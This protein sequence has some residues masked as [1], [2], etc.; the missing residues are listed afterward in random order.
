[1]L[2]TFAPAGLRRWKTAQMQSL[3]THEKG[4]L[5]LFTPNVGKLCT[6]SWELLH[7]MLVFYTPNVGKIYTILSV[8]YWNTI[9]K[10]VLYIHTMISLY[11]KKRSILFFNNNNQS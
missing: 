6:K 8:T 9:N 2:G 5:G 10:S 11:K 3:K 4:I 7:K 1:M